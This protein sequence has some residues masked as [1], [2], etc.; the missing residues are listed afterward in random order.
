MAYSG[1]PDDTCVNRPHLHYELRSMDYGTTYNPVNWIDA[2]WHSLGIVG[3]FNYPLFQIDL[4]NTHR[5]LSLD[6]QPD[7]VFG[8]GVL[9]GYPLADTYPPNG[10]LRPA[11]NPPLRSQVTPFDA[12]AGWRTRIIG[13]SK[14]CPVQWW[15]VQNPDRLWVLDG[16][17]GQRAL[18]YEWSADLGQIV[19][20]GVDAPPAY[21]SPDSTRTI[22]VEGENAVIRTLSD[23]AAVSVFTGGVMPTLSTDNSKLLWTVSQPSPQN[24]PGARPLM[25]VYMA[26]AVDRAEARAILTAEGAS[27]L[28]LDADRLLLSLPGVRPTTLLAVYDTRDGSQFTL[29]TFVGLRNLTVSPDGARVMFYTPYQQNP[30][31]SAIYVLETQPGAVPQKIDW[32]GGWRWRDAESVYYIPF[33]WQDAV[34]TLHYYNVVTGEDVQLT[35]PDET[36]FGVMNAE[37]SVSPDGTRIVFRDVLT[38]EMALLEAVGG[39]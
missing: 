8:G 22:R 13:F 10:S 28:W 18:V 39:G 25:T 5:W 33:Q 14:C 35:T 2:E 38:R 15:D 37:W 4:Y 12:S 3:G 32:F 9:N 17:V 1:D 20:P 26:D 11:V 6:D 27:A 21:T 19:Q 34:Q 36:P 16:G 23:G 24:V 29:G 30:D 31:D 7:V